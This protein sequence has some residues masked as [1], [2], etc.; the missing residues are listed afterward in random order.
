MSLPLEP[1]ELEQAQRALKDATVVTLSAIGYDRAMLLAAD[2]RLCVYID[3]C[4]ANPEGHN[5]YELLALLRFLE[6]SR[7]YL[8]K[9]VELKRFVYFYESLSFPGQRGLSRYKLTP[10]QV[11]QAAGIFSFYY[12]ETPDKRVCRE[13]LLFVPRKFSKTTFVAAVA[14]YDLL[15]GDSNAQGYVAAN[16]YDQAKICF[17]I[18]RNVL[19]ALD[20]KMQRFKINREQVFSLAPGRSSFIRCLSS[21][22]DKLDGLNASVVVMDEFSQSDSAAL[23]NVLTSSMGARR[24]PL[25]LVITTASEKRDTPFYEA[26]GAYKAILRGERFNDDLFAHIFEPDPW[27]EEDSPAT[28]CKVQPH[29]GVTV[30]R[31]FYEHEWQRAQLS[32]DIL[33]EFRN[34]YLNLFARDERTV[35]VRGEQ[36][37]AASL[38]VSEEQLLGQRCVSA[39]DLSVKDDFSAV[40]YL[41]YLPERSI[42]GRN[43]PFH[44]VTDYYLPSDAIESHPNRELYRRWVDAG[45]LNLIAGEVI[46]SRRIADDMLSKPYSNMGI[47]Y[48]PAHSKEFTRIME[49]APNV[50][51]SYLYAIRQSYMTFTPLVEIFDTGLARGQITFEPNPITSYCFRNAVLDVDRHGLMKPLKGKA[52]DKIDGCITNLMCLWMFDNVKTFV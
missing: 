51:A 9:G 35:W 4:I 46:D 48:D 2:K 40:T 29:L 50:G 10:V 42:G 17:D 20:P 13:A 3:E 33:K 24:N 47:G 19:K 39:V 37:D 43:V 6:F 11:F 36:I 25:T 14:I 16:S 12:K 7:K 5:T 45:H 38:S 8:F 32:S 52:I 31:D 18:I 21:N 28:W 34:K 44:S 27:D 22:P 23:K 30:Q 15:F 41:F 26:L 49:T 1:K